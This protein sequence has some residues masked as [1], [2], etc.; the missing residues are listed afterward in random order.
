[1]SNI[2]TILESLNE[3]T[4]QYEIFTGQR[5]EKF[6]K[7]LPEMSDE[8]IN[9]ISN[10]T[11]EILSKCV[12]PSYVDDVPV[13][14]TGL[15][16]GYVQ[17]GKTMSFTG[18]IALAS[19]NN[20]KLIIVLAG[21]TKILLEQTTNRLR[22]DLNDRNSYE[23]ISEGSKLY[24]KPDLIAEIINNP[25]RERTVI[26]TILKHYKHIKDIKTLLSRNE[27]KSALLN[28]SV[29]IIDDEADQASLNGL[30]RK[31]WKLEKNNKMSDE[32]RKEYEE[33]K[34]FTSTYNNILE[35][36]N[37]LD[38][39]SYIQYT[40]TPQANILAAQRDLMKPSWSVVLEPGSKYTGG[41]I[42]FNDDLEL[43][44]NIKSENDE[45]DPEMPD[46]LQEAFIL[47]LIESA[48]LTY[49]NYPLVK[50]LKKIMKRTSMMVHAD[51]LIERNSIY[52]R[53][54][55]AYC[56]SIRRGIKADEEETNILLKESY[57][58]VQ[59]MLSD[60]FDIFP[61]FED[62]RKVIQ[63]YVLDEI[64]FW[65][66]AGDGDSFVDWE[67]GNHHVLIGGQK[68]DR[69]FTVN[70]LIITYLP[71]QTK[72]ISNADTIEQRCR[73]F[74][75]KKDYIEA[76]RVFL[77]QQSINEFQE[78]V[79]HEEKLRGVLKSGNI[80]DYYDNDILMRIVGLNL[81]SLNKIPGDLI[82]IDF[83]NYKFLE[84]DIDN[85]THTKS[86]IKTFLEKCHYKGELSYSKSQ[87]INDDNCHRVSTSNVENILQNLNKLK[88]NRKKDNL[89]V[90]QFTA[91]LGDI[92]PAEK[93]WV[94]EM[95]YK[96]IGFRPR[97]LKE[98]GEL[99]ALFTN[100]PPEFGDTKLLMND[101]SGGVFHKEYNNEIIIQIHKV[102]IKAMKNPNSKYK[103]YEGQVFDIIA[104]R[105]PN[106]NSSNY[107][108]I[109]YD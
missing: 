27:I 9:N 48:L 41:K 66:V 18:L 70:E 33:I 28:K 83:Y 79:A 7:D 98:N 54:L 62:I 46:E 105:Y 8:E 3:N 100:H 53:W 94:I 1:M 86:I 85:I 95:A 77:P 57:P 17:S 39:H 23:I 51:R 67:N 68:L 81:T 72:S 58:K 64:R 45:E 5:F 76:C 15:V 52:K 16:F 26:L 40:A 69:G 80:M 63:F 42:F 29:L 44:V 12:P 32:E 21:T 65:F 71:R 92:N 30:A 38:C 107:I 34:K 24:D 104:F 91:L 61:S 82:R 101:I 55:E 22:K 96:R 87:K 99:M 50:R 4:F 109:N 73:F 14:N 88:V 6:I 31:N 97:S 49:D 74:G 35:L 75:Y 47:F 13:S 43:I 78:Y 90:N 103:D 106:K 59:K 36:K 11:I 108:Q 19:D 37:E 102:K 10:S 93:V 84:P 89:I 25:H 2:A 56:N 20:Y 60:Y